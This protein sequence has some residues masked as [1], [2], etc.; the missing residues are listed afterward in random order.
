MDRKPARYLLF[1]ALF[2]FCGQLLA[3]PLLDCPHASHDVPMVMAEP[4]ESADC[5]GMQTDAAQPKEHHGL[6]QHQAD[7]AC[8]DHLCGHCLGGSGVFIPALNAAPPACHS[9]HA[10]LA[11]AGLLSSHSLDLLRPPQAV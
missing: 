11:A 9:G 1:L 3:A 6:A 2:A 8:C 7:G 4:S 5:H 10:S